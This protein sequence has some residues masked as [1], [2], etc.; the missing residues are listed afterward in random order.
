MEPLHARRSFGQ[1]GNYDNLNDSHVGAWSPSPTPVI[2]G[3]DDGLPELFVKSLLVQDN[4]TMYKRGYTPRKSPVHKANSQSASFP[5]LDEVDEH[6]MS[7]EDKQ[8]LSMYRQMALSEEEASPISSPL[9]M[10]QRHLNVVNV[11]PG[12]ALQEI[13]HDSPFSTIGTS[14]SKGATPKGTEEK[15]DHVKLPQPMTIQSYTPRLTPAKAP[16]PTEFNLDNLEQMQEW[17]NKKSASRPPSSSRPLSASRQNRPL[18]AK[19]TPRRRALG[20]SD[21]QPRQLAKVDG[22]TAGEGMRVDGCQVDRGRELQHMSEELEKSLIVDGFERSLTNELGIYTDPEDAEGPFDRHLDMHVGGRDI[23]P[24]M[25]DKIVPQSVY[26]IEQEA[27]LVPEGIVGGSSLLRADGEGSSAASRGSRPASGG[28]PSATDLTDLTNLTCTGT[29]LLPLPP[30]SRLPALIAAEQ[31]EEHHEWQ[32]QRQQ[33]LQTPAQHVM[34]RIRSGIALNIAEHAEFFDPASS[35]TGI[36]EPD[37]VFAGG[38]VHEGSR[39]PSREKEGQT[40]TE[41]EDRVKLAASVHAA[42]MLARTENVQDVT[43]QDVPT[44]DSLKINQGPIRGFVMCPS[45]NTQVAL[46]TNQKLQQPLVLNYHGG[47]T[48][49]HEDRKVR[50]SCALTP[51]GQSPYNSSDGSRRASR[52]GSASLPPAPAPQVLQELAELKQQM[53]QV[54]GERQRERE[55]HQ[56]ALEAAEIALK[57]ALAANTT[58]KDATPVAAAPSAAV[59]ESDKDK[60]LKQL[61]EQLAAAEQTL[62]AAG[63]EL[64]AAK[65]TRTPV[66]PPTS[67]GDAQSASGKPPTAPSSHPPSG[68]RRAPSTSKSTAAPTPTKK[69]N[70]AKNTAPKVDAVE[71]QNLLDD[72]TSLKLQLESATAEAAAA[73]AQHEQDNKEKEGG[74]ASQRLRHERMQHTHATHIAHSHAQT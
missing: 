58:V 7:P 71:F 12:E 25:R 36:K 53:L 57:E 4:G 69:E 64:A 6:L 54:Q 16:Q 29:A 22:A 20:V 28:R 51:R 19:G 10:R 65:V 32:Q 42:L 68:V 56:K 52:P 62:A 11:D 66:V 43:N 60:E 23:A 26:R 13:D 3:Y 14:I 40:S 34:A 38:E 67:P 61:C 39:Q 47:G 8:L 35:L 45:C 50:L 59:E 33:Q 9:R 15:L 21:S 70:T 72:L 24:R 55:Q 30:A 37:A 18:S 17:R 41:E 44:D 46:G 48:G 1:V 63:Q 27:V 5:L 2:R 31:Q 49:S 74:G 73:K